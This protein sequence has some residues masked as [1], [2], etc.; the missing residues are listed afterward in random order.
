MEQRYRGDPINDE[1]YEFPIWGAEPRYSPDFDESEWMN[2]RPP[3]EEDAEQV[4]SLD[5]T[6]SVLDEEPDMDDMVEKAGPEFFS[7]MTGHL[8]GD[9]RAGPYPGQFNIYPFQARSS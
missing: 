4:F 5:A 9:D 2:L 6:W 3:E 7:R 1:P 8:Q